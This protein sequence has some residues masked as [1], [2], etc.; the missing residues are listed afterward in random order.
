[1]TIDELLGQE[2]MESSEIEYKRQLE[3]E[4]TENWLKTVAGFSNAEGGTLYIGV[5][6][7]T[8]KLLGFPREKADA[9]RN[10][11]NSQVNEHISPRP[12]YK[13]EFLRY[14]NNGRELFILRIVIAESPLKPIILKYKGA[15][16]HIL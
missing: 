4:K 12:E 10:F 13:I 7:G 11:F 15:F 14:E 6:D 8:H 3:R 2:N 1:M 5:E 9:E 16:V